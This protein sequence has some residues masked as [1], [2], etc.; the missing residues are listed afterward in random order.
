MPLLKALQG[1]QVPLVTSLT[2]GFS[3]LPQLT[4]LQPVPHHS[5]RA[6]T[7]FLPQGLG[8]CCS[9][10]WT[11]SL[12]RVHPLLLL[13]FSAPVSS[14]SASGLFAILWEACD[15]FI[16]PFA[17]FLA[18]FPAGMDGPPAR[19]ICLIPQQLPSGVQRAW[20]ITGPQYSF[21]K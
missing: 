4:L 18:I 14:A 19:S 15:Y 8:T 17:W 10:L 2:S 11:P 16:C 9:R 5:L 12:Q 1:T 7:T 3:S 6:L 21:K 20:H 13:S